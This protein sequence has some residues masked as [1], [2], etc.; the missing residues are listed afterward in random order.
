M[1]L[2]NI[3]L[4]NF[5][6][7]Q[8]INL[9][10]SKQ[11]NCFVGENGSGKT[12]LLDAI[13]YL[14]MTKS[15][16]NPVDQQNI[17][18]GAPFFT[19]QG[20]FTKERKHHVFCSLQTGQKKVFKHNKKPYDKLSEHI[21]DFPVVLIAPDDTDV[22]REGSEIRRRFF[23]SI[24]AQTDRIYLENL[25]RYNQVL[26]QRNS[27]L[28]QF[29][30]RNYFDKDLLEPYSRLLLQTGQ[31]L[32]EKRKDF[33]AGFKPEVA[34]HYEN[35]SEG[36]EKVDLQY[37]SDLGQPDHEKIFRE[38]IKR[39]LLLQRTTSGVHKDDYEFLINGYPLKKTGSQGQQKSFLISLKLTHF[40]VVKNS[41]GY[42]PILLLDDIF[43]K[44]DDKRIAKLM[45]MVAGDAFGQLFVTDALPERAARILENIKA[46]VKVFNF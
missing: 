39:D 10:F 43:D 18:H 3:S 15:A 13:H 27:L 34:R 16:F 30:S 11:I 35:I 21:G 46:D 36:K 4:I 12:N 9:V 31:L 33:I 2:E 29:S 20:Q 6:N 22:I 28:K 38:N 32:Y 41:K 25:I 26:R 42:K 23:D 44:L 17:R 1:Y 45:A 8:E 5:K 37:V 40:D 19:V 24:L 14:S 7:Y